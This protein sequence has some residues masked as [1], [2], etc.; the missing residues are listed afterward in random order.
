M[1]TIP[2]NPNLII[3]SEIESGGFGSL[4]KVRD[5]NDNN[6]YTLKRIKIINN[7]IMDNQNEINIIKNLD[8]EYIVKYY[9]SFQDGNNFYIVMEY[10]DNSDFYNFI[11]EH[12]ENNKLIDEK[13]IFE[14]IN[15]ICH[16]LKEIH[17]KKI[18]H[19]DIRP[20]NIF[21]NKNNKIKIGDFGTSKELIN[22]EYA[23]TKKGDMAY[24]AP[25]MLQEAKYNNKE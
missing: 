9:D 19:R 18:I 24:I 14:I 11:K 17:Y 2:N 8:S 4:Y 7:N 25:E 3:D 21:M 23:T 20:K 5:T 12:K 10:C 13:I 15:N 22:R 1:E 6:I 16:G